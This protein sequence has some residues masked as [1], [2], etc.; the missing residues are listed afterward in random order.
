[1]NEEEL[2][3]Q[4]KQEIKQEMK[5]ERRKRRIILFI[6]AIVIIAVVYGIGI[7]LQNSR[8]AKEYSMQELE[9]YKT[10]LSITTENWKDYIVIE[11]METESKDA[12]GKVT[13]KN[14]FTIIRLKE[15]ICGYAIL[16]FKVQKGVFDNEQVVTL[17]G[18]H[19]YKDYGLSQLH[20]QGKSRTEGDISIYNNRY[21][22]NDI[23]CIEVIGYLYTIDIPDNLWQTDYYNYNK[24]CIRLTGYKNNNSW[25][26]LFKEID[27][28]LEEKGYD[29]NYIE[30]LSNYEYEKYQEENK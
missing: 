5:K 4:L 21:T 10:E 13:S 30:A 16:R 20:M 9:Q 8:K 25:R 27:T 17:V 6:I 15:N 7:I 22:I 23:E 26:T 29:T 1:M 3:K 14:E 19:D 24:E 12:F 18:G 11:D 28:E 2:R